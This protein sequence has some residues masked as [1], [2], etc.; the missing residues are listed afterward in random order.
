[1]LILFQFLDRRFS[2]G[3]SYMDYGVMT[4]DWAVVIFSSG[5][6]TYTHNQSRDT[7]IS[8]FTYSHTKMTQ[9]LLRLRKFLCILMVK[10]ENNKG[11]ISCVRCAIPKFSVIDLI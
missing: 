3:I 1:M 6:I 5:L 10:F 8:W 11:F 4:T 9:A 7:L 2:N